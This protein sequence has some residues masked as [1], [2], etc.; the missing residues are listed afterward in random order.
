MWALI[1]IPPIVAIAMSGLV[2]R[3]ARPLARAHCLRRD[4]SVAAGMA[5]QVIGDYRV[6]AAIWRTTGD[7]GLGVG[8]A[9]G[10]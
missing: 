8:H 2:P 9:E 6:A 3:T 7:P 1:A 5:L 10:R 4:Q